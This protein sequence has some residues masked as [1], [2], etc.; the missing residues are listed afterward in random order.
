M[1]IDFK[2]TDNSKAV[3]DEMKLGIERALTAIGI[4]AESHAKENLYPGHGFD[5]GRLRNSITHAVRTDEKSVYIGSNVE[6]ARIVEV[7]SSKR[8]PKPY[9]KPAAT[10]HTAEYQELAKRA[11]KG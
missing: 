2:I 10:E 5:T 7:G 3:L 9:L 8:K 11:L 4:T 6:Y 1:P